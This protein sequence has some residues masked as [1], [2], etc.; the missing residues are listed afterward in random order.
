VGHTEELAKIDRTIKDSEI[1]IRTVKSS[2][3]VIDAEIELVS[4][5]Q[6]NLKEN[7][8]CLKSKKIVAIAIEFK[9]AREELERAKKRITALNSDRAHFNKALKETEAV[10]KQARIDYERMESAAEN[11]VLHFK[12][13]KKDG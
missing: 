2:I 13:E 12:S 9:K 3:D 11:N 8:K 7:V 10:L 4:R 5:L 1:R 6:D